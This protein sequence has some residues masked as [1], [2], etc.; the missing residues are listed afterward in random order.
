MFLR[1]ELC[2]G[3]D[4]ITGG[5]GADI[6]LGGL[7]SDRLV[8]GWG[9]DILVS[10]QT[11]YESDE[12]LNKLPEIMGLTA[13]QAEWLSGKDYFERLGNI[14]GD[15]PRLDR[16][17]SNYYLSFG[18]TVWDDGQEDKLTGSRGK[19]RF[20]LSGDDL[21]VD[22]GDSTIALALLCIQFKDPFDDIYTCGFHLIESYLGE[23]LFCLE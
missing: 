6:L 1:V 15:S 8:G 21:A 11:A 16:L 14:T 4:E 3:D 10:D 7:G 19:D 12:S 22:I 5:D 9:D 2:D 20:L 23:K 18:L 13:I 17:N